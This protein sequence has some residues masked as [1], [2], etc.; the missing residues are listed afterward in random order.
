MIAHFV[1]LPQGR[2]RLRFAGSFTHDERANAPHIINE[3][4]S[5]L[6]LC[7]DISLFKM[8]PR[9]ARIYLDAYEFGLF[10]HRPVS[11]IAVIL[12]FLSE[13]FSLF[14]RINSVAK[15]DTAIFTCHRPILSI[16]RNERSF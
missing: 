16:E 4:N 3:R 14:A 5:N 9:G 10:V 15:N 6:K 11:D 2:L 13:L 7:H 8:R 12:H 1:N